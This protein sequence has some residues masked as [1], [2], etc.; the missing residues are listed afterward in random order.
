[1]PS[2]MRTYGAITNLWEGGEMGE[3]YSQRL[4]PRLKRGLK[5]NWHVN[6]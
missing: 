5:G 3:K 2:T 6:D 4:K 1:L